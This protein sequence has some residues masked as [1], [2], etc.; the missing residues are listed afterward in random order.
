VHDASVGGTGAKSRLHSLNSALYFEAETERVDTR[1][2]H[3]R[4]SH[5][6]YSHTRCS[7]ALYSSRALAQSAVA[8]LAEVLQQHFCCS[9]SA[10]TKLA[11]SAVA[12]LAESVFVLLYQ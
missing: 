4:Y 7:H 8:A 5:T 1:Y 10:A 6:R 11:E 2:S 9:T 12:A 3:T